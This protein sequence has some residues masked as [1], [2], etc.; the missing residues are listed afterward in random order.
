M[1][2]NKRTFVNVL[3]QYLR[4]IISICLSLYTT[5]LVLQALGKS[6]YGLFMLVGGVVAMLGFIT[7]AMV[8]TTQ[9]HLSF[10]YG[11]KDFNQVKIVF[12]NALILHICLALLLFVIL[13]VLRP[14]FITQEG[15]FL[16]ID[17]QRI[18]AAKLVY[19]TSVVTL[20]LSFV[21]APFRAIFIARE[22]IVFITIVDVCDAVIKLALVLAMLVM[23]T[24]KL[25]MYALIFLT[26][27]LLNL[28]VFSFFANYKYTECIFFPRFKLLRWKEIRKIFSFAGWTVY[29]NACVVFRTQGISLLL[30]HFFRS[31][32]INSAYGLGTQVYGS[33]A[34]LSQ[35][36]LNA[37][38]PRVIKAEGAGDR[39]S[40]LK[41]AG[42]TSKFC[43]LLLS[44]FT[45]PLCF[46]MRGVLN[47]W[48]GEN[49]VPEH[50]VMFCQCLIISMICDQLTAGLITANQA[51]GK[52]RNYSL[53]INT[54]KLTTIPLVWMSLHFGY[55][56][57]WTMYIYIFIEFL[58]AILRLLY[59]RRTTSL[60]MKEYSKQVFLRILLPTLTVCS[61]CL[62]AMMMP[63]MKFRFL[64]TLALAA[65]IDTMVVYFFALEPSEKLLLKKFLKRR[66]EH[67]ESV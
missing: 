34:F 3:A 60:S 37:M 7:N 53:L 44:M 5:R 15:G 10:N 18:D 20:C 40:M 23:D 58:C 49:N 14:L 19:L 24:D 47:F 25:V 57:I 28:I 67:D 4:T 56:V 8:V 1:D 9:R 39:Q 42:V 41:L 66:H 29:S 27:Q 63:Q 55:P 43:F 45:I 30:N 32:V 22:N 33:T 50:A 2:K 52:I 6:D 16:S 12:A 36:I 62:L 61:V 35:S 48:L 51:I 46:E 38:S 13:M 11:K 26:V 59:M 31:T 21:T 64:L 54:T 17:N 65:V